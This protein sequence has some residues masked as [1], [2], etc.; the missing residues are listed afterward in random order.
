MPN[1]SGN[2]EF[3][4]I[5]EQRPSGDRLLGAGAAG[6]ATLVV[7]GLVAESAAATPLP[8]SKPGRPGGLEP[9]VSRAGFTAVPPN[10]RDR[11][12]VPE[13]FRSDVVIR[14]GDRVEA[15]APAFDVRHQTP[16]AQ[17]KQFGYNN[18]YVGLLPLARGQQ[19]LVVNHE[20]T[21]ENLMFPTGTDPELV[22]EVAMAAHGMSVVQL[23]RGKRR[24]SWERTPIGRAKLNRRIHMDTTF[25]LTGPAAG[26]ERLR[27]G[28]DPKGRWV[29]G[30]LNNCAGG[31]TPWGTV[32]SGEENFNQYFEGTPD[33]SYA[34]SYARYG[35]NGS[36]TRGWATVDSRFDLAQEP[37]EPFRFGWV[38]ELDPYDPHST[39]RKH[40]MLGRF[41]HEGA[42][43]AVAKSGHVVAYMGDDERGDY[44][45]KFVSAQKM[46]KGRSKAARRHNMTLL[47]KG[48][49]Y[50]ARF[51]DD[52]SPD[53]TY[54]G[55]GTWI[56]LTSHRRSYVDG[57]SVADVLIDTRLAADTVA[58]TRMD[59]PEDI[60]PNPV[61]GRV[62]CALT[63]NSNRGST[64]P[65]DEA[66]PITS[67]M[68]RESLGAGQRR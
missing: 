18:D 67:S 57:F 53:E 32:L 60:E 27:T 31:L 55:G 61:N 24:G 6:A 37:H 41:K 19:L 22:K 5:A 8:T 59:R 44:I 64:F 35:I 3:R 33:P 21:N 17:R 38:V 43:I 66:N 58:P 56:P 34:E 28:V 45:Y 29:K 25:K 13:G 11:V 46:A 23:R 54:D 20:Y 15:G 12:T 63:N 2:P 52:R 68:V 14:W 30:T 1:T 26:D 9:R 39:P 62:Y 47:T 16:A 51:N 4:T 50:V 48:T 65:A 36:S 7:S 42:N 40:T 49:L 10:N